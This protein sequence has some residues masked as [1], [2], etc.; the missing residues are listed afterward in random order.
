MVESV[1]GG[2]EKHLLLYVRVSIKIESNNKISY[3]DSVPVTC[4][5]LPFITVEEQYPLIKGAD[6]LGIKV[7]PLVLCLDERLAA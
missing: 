5:P 6:Y 1:R 7:L 4:R 2:G 3:F